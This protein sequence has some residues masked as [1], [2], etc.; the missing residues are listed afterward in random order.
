M[1][2]YALGR[3][4][5]LAGGALM[6]ATGG[7]A[8]AGCT[9]NGSSGDAGSV[10][11]PT[12]AGA[13][14][15]GDDW[16]AVRA[17]FALDP[18]L[19]HFAAYVLAAHPQPVRNAI[20]R[21][22]D[23]LDVDTAAVVH[24][25]A[26][27]DDA[28]RSAAAAY[29]RVAPGEIA[30]TD[31]TTMGLS[32]VYHGIALEP[33]DHVLTT[34][35][36]FYSAH[37]SLR[38]AAARTGAEVEHISLYDD[39]TEASVDEMASRIATAIRPETRIVALTWVHSG[40]GVKIPVRQIADVLADANEGREPGRR[41]LLCLDAIHGLGAEEDGPIDL[42]CDVFISGTHKW[43]FGPRGTG[44]VW[45]SQQAGEA[46]T[47]IIP[48]F[49]APSFGN[50]LTGDN[51][52]SPF[53]LGGTP[54]GYQAFEH[55]WAVSEAFEFHRSIGVDRVAARTHELATRLKEGLSAI[56]AVRVVTPLDPEV[57]SGLVCCEVAGRRPAE[58]VERLR[59]EHSVVTSV[60]P[61]REPYVR[62]GTSIVT[63]P[64]QVD[65]AAA[66]IEAMT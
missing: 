1:T 38:L 10:S 43:L 40:T 56:A 8:L 60:T 31:S 18:D 58:V 24:D 59:A 47:P 26:A 13:N 35:H 49:T 9:A 23:A 21:W 50:W 7:A 25:E 32:L 46:V 22:R 54:G 20:A 63:T 6:A 57:S 27:N 14:T 36:D 33:G 29:L 28:V 19:A 48:A 66:A 11:A 34:T 51:V 39:P 4:A 41:A 37:E 15:S 16:D 55:R 2:D 17:H 5:L 30:L 3:R 53:G 64:E 45:A 62:F 61:Y 52:P 42:G 44:L 12:T 65:A